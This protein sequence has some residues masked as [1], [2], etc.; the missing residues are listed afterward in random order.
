[1][2]DQRRLL[3]PCLQLEEEIVRSASP[4][5][6]FFPV[7]NGSKTCAGAPLAG[8]WAPGTATAQRVRSPTKARFSRPATDGFGF[9]K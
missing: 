1:M 2:Q 8:F 9:R 7:R 5:L 4:G 6:S 3:L